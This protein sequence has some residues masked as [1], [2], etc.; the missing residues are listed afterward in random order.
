MGHKPTVKGMA[1]DPAKVTAITEM[2]R[3]TSK[4]GV[5][6]FLGMCQY[7]S[8]FT[9]NLSERV[10]PLRKLTKQ[11]AKFIWAN[12]HK[13]AFQTAKELI[14]T[15]T[16]LRY[17]DVTKPVTLQVNASEEAIGVALLQEGQPVCFTS[18][19]LDSTEKNYAQI[20]KECLAKECLTLAG[21]NYY[22]SYRLP[23][24]GDHF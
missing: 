21:L 23:T 5:Q 2:A 11:D 13:S 14:A 17:Y 1:T 6:R 9:P 3:P 4:T 18:D 20:E 15:T 7:L 12:T 8:K 22:Y 10:L 24:A 16:V 19:C